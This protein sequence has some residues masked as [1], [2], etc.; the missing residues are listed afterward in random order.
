MEKMCPRPPPQNHA[1]AHWRM[2][3]HRQPPP[4][5]PARRGWSPAA[6]DADQA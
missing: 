1:F 6:T 3:H 2:L 4:L 5:T